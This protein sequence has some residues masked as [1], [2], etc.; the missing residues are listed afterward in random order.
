MNMSHATPVPNWVRHAIGRLPV[1]P[2]SLLIAQALNRL[3][4]PMVDAATQQALSG[5]VVE[6]H[7]S[8][9]GLTCRLIAEPGGMRCAS[10]GQPFAVRLSATAPVF[11]QLLRGREDPDTL[12][13][14]RRMT[15]EG[16]TEFGLL[17][18]NTLD[19]VGPPRWPGHRGNGAQDGR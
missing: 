17:L 16:D 10:A 9:L 5:R 8:D 6:L 7:V 14:D 3:W 18:K 11:W 19:A 15:M 2:P 13:F 4:W 12:F 1:W